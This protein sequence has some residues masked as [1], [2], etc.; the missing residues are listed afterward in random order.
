MWSRRL[1][2]S[3]PLWVALLA[4]IPAAAQAASASISPSLDFR[5]WEMIRASGLIAYA[6]LSVSVIVGI[7]VRVRGLDWLMKRA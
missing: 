3:W 6:L 1:Q 5:I 4:L 7:A 2:R